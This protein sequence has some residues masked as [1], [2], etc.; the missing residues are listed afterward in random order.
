MVIEGVSSSR[1]PLETGRQGLAGVT[2]NDA[3]VSE[4]IAYFCLPAKFYYRTFQM[5][6]LSLPI[7][8]NNE[9]KMQHNPR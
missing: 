7:L 9:Q 4:L 1:S 8:Y 6:I 5:L 2:E 3:S